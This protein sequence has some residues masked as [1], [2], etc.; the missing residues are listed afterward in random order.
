MRQQRE[1][2]RADDEAA[3]HR[4]GQRAHVRR[5]PA[6]GLLQVGHHGIDGEPGRGAGQ[7]GQH[8][9]SGS[10]RCGVAA[11]ASVVDGMRR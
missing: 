3:L 5:R 4:R 10:T 6:V 7:L 2:Q 8:Q 9:C 11:A 1:H